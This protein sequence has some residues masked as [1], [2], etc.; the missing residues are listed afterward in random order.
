MKTFTFVTALIAAIGLAAIVAKL[1]ERDHNR[2]LG[3][4]LTYEPCDDGSLRFDRIRLEAGFDGD[5]TLS[6]RVT[7]TTSRIIRSATG[8]FTLHILDDRVWDG[9]PSPCT[10]CLM[11]GESH[12]CEQRFLLSDWRK[13]CRLPRRK[14]LPD[15]CASDR[16]TLTCDTTG[17]PLA[18]TTTPTEGATH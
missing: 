16:W 17:Q 6:Y 3:L 7:N 14:P 13:D 10:I 9:L 15:A 18:A 8:F 12:D 4:P 2:Q 1:S 5:L 11:P